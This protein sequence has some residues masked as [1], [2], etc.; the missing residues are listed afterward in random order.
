MLRQSLRAAVSRVHTGSVR[1]ASSL[2]VID[3]DNKTMDKASLKAVAA[4]TKIGGDIT[5]LVSGSGC[6]AVA[7]EASTI[8]GVTKVL[9]VD[10]ASLSDH[11]DVNL[12]STILAAHG[13]SPF[14]HIVGAATSKGKGTLPRVAAKL[15]VG[16]VS[17]ITDVVDE[18]TFV[19]GVY[20]GNIVETVKS[21]DAVKVV[22]VRST[23][24][25]NPAMGA[26]AAPVTPLAAPAACTKTKFVSAELSKSERPELASASRVVSGGRGVKNKEGFDIIYDVADA[27]DAAVGASR[28]AVDA[29]FCPNEIQIGQTGKCVAPDMYLAIGISGAIQHL[30]GMKDS[31]VIAAINK[32]PEAPIFE[33]ADYGLEAD[34]F[35]ACP[36]LIEKLKK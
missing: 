26:A 10:D 16:A 14:T 27:M 1:H 34:L 22:S 18:D 3:H 7:D 32:D 13:A 9:L 4:A 21:N 33:I 30:A 6:A 25:D 29:G 2:V 23:A 24:F 20:A 11:L 12:T 31:K 5:A 17:E 35:K 15:D 36:E 28:A 19:H 8:T